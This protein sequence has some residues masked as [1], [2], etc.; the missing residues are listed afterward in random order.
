ME[1]NAKTRTSVTSSSKKRPSKKRGGTLIIIGGHEDHNGERVILKE[2]AK[3]VKGG[4][5]VLATIASHNPDGYLKKYQASFAELGIPDVEELYIK[6]RV[7]AAHPDKIAALDDV[8][9]IFFSG[10]DQLRITSQIGETPLYER[11]REIYDNGGVIA[12]TSA[13]A[14]MMS[15]TMLVRGRGKTSSRAGDLRITAGL[16]FMNDVII[17]QHFAERGRIGRLIG[18]VSQNPRVLGI[19]LD[20][21]TA[22]VVEGD[23]FDVIG[24]GAV[25][26]VDGS[27]ITHS[28]AAEAEP[29]SPLSI[30]DLRLHV[31]SAGNAFDLKARRPLDIPLNSKQSFAKKN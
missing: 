16:G 15:E 12:G 26:I 10:G 5:L 14:S 24:S 21:D 18:A 3:H 20:E 29:E 1:H 27:S 8:N 13:G 4:R 22:I 11:V 2:V 17:D 30:Y 6:N 28:N 25:Y 31:L 7:E 9:A 23:R 19:G